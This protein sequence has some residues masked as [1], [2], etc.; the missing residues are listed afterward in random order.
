MR[1]VVSE[2]NQCD[3]P[4]LYT[5]LCSYDYG[6]KFHRKRYYAGIPHWERVIEGEEEKKKLIF[7]PPFS[8]VVDSD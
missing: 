2:E 7:G 1:I 4:D 3:L 5:Q 6:D 8:E